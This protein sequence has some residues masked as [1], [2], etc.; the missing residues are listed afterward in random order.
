MGRWAERQESETE[1]DRLAETE[2]EHW[3]EMELAWVRNGH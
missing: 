2:K 3:L 1:S